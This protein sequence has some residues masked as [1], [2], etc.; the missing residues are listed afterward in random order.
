[1]INKARKVEPLKLLAGNTAEM[2]SRILCI[3]CIHLSI[4][5]FM[6]I[7]SLIIWLF[8]PMILTVGCWFFRSSYL[9]SCKPWL[10]WVFND[11]DM[12]GIY[13][14]W[15]S[16]LLLLDLQTWDKRWNLV[17]VAYYVAVF[18]HPRIQPKVTLVKTKTVEITSETLVQN[19]TC[20]IFYVLH[21]FLLG[22]TIL[23]NSRVYLV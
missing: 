11:D 15:C 21:Y 6:V 18:E 12:F 9:Q 23:C 20:K 17:C 5:C 13:V 4:F 16:L 19:L 14:Y 3:F 2:F 10:R 1:M 22:T 8:M 7:V